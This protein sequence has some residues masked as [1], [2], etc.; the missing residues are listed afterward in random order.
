VHKDDRVMAR[1]AGVHGAIKVGE[2]RVV[3]SKVLRG[4]TASS[5]RATHV[6]APMIR[7]LTVLGWV[8]VGPRGV[9]EPATHGS[10][11]GLHSSCTA[12]F[13]SSV[14]MQVRK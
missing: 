12:S 3:V 1:P 9:C 7:T 5:A 2:S 13:T 4:V 8:G 6:M 10:Q 14:C 11:R